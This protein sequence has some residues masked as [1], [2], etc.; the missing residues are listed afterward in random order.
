MTQH[1]DKISI[2]DMRPAPRARPIRRQQLRQ[3]VPLS[4]TTIY[5]LEARGLFPRRF[6]LTNR[7]VAWDL[8]EVEAW[9]EQRR[10]ESLA[11]AVAKAPTPDIRLRRTRPV[12]VRTT[13]P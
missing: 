4:D 6:N 9:I 8:V 12:K 10:Q 11:G 2:G 3:I 1:I 7:C 5:E 13:N